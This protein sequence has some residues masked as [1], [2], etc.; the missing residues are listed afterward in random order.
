[1][2]SNSNNRPNLEGLPAG[3]LKKIF[4]YVGISKNRLEAQVQIRTQPRSI[5]GDGNSERIIQEYRSF[6]KFP[7]LAHVSRRMRMA[8]LSVFIP[9]NV[10]VFN[11]RNGHT[12]RIES[13]LRAPAQKR[14]LSKLK[15][16]VLELELTAIFPYTV[17]WADSSTPI[18]RPAGEIVP[19]RIDIDINDN[20]GTKPIDISITFHEAFSTECACWIE[21]LGF[22]S[23]EVFNSRFSAPPLFWGTKNWHHDFLYFFLVKLERHLRMLRSGWVRSYDQKKGIC[24]RCLKPFVT[25]SKKGPGKMPEHETIDPIEIACDDVS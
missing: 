23:Q 6:P 17:H 11:N 12:D 14:Y 8:T 1:M 15:H 21:R 20:N 9:E 22:L 18:H 5:I 24:A 7:A 10:F 16:V 3:I 2:A 25:W 13:W 19:A 4:E